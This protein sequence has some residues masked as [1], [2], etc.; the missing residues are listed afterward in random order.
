MI[1]FKLESGPTQGLNHTEVCNNFIH[2]LPKPIQNKII[3]IRKRLK[4]NMQ[5]QHMNHKDP[6]SHCIYS[7][8]LFACHNTGK[9]LLHF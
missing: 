8:I 2:S 3:D 6:D 9:P 1:K 5:E 4:E 7:R